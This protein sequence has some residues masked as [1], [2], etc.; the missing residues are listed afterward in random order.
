M[1]MKFKGLNFELIDGKIVLVD[2][3]D[4]AKCK[5]KNLKGLFKFIEIAQGR[6]LKVLIITSKTSLTEIPPING[7]KYFAPSF[8]TTL[9]IVK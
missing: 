6:N 2:C 8:F 4:F 5:D 9:V 1:E 7:P 3:M